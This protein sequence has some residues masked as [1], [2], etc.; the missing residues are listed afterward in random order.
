MSAVPRLVAPV[1]PATRLVERNLRVFRNRWLVVVSAFFEPLFFLLGVGVG[2][3]ALVGEVTGPDGREV[4]YAVYVAP[5]MLATSAM[6]GAVFEGTFN[7]FFKLKYE[8]TYDAVLATPMTTR[9]VA[10]GEIASIQLRGLFYAAAFLVVAAALGLVPS[11]WG[12]AAIPSASLIGFAFAAV[13]MAATTWMRSW[14][15]FDLVQTVTIPLFLFSATFYPLD[16][17]PPAL[18]TV[19][20]LSPLYHGVELCRAFMLGAFD[21]T[22][23]AHAAVLVATAAVG[24][25]VTG[26]RL[27]RLL[28]R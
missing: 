27:E 3:G 10:V 26:R 15:D 16:V 25:V 18:Q 21:V 20:Q 4:A 19:A 17:Y 8:R 13:G 7:V 12:L 5:A 2:V 23:L 1:G 14:Q 24:L 6:N 11:W 9:D 22:L 28:R